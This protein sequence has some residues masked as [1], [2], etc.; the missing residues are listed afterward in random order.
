MDDAL[1]EQCVDATDARGLALVAFGRGNVP[2]SIVP[3]LADAIAGGRARD[4]VVTMRGRPRAARGTAT[5]AAD[6]HLRN[7]SARSSPAISPAPR[8]GC[9]RWSRSAPRRTRRKPKSCADDGLIIR[10]AA[11][12]RISLYGLDRLPADVQLVACGR[13]RRRERPRRSHPRT[14]MRRPSRPSGSA[15]AH[16]HERKDERIVEQLASG[17]LHGVQARLGEPHPR[18]IEPDRVVAR[19]RTR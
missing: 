6:L 8:H 3:A 15:V 2:P 18:V 4:G 11:I 14:K 5:T 10:R 12:R 19:R 16:L 1:I 13:S 7:G 9:C 17:D